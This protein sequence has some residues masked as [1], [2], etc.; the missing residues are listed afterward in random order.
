SLSRAPTPHSRSADEEAFLE[1]S[2]AIKA[3]L[4]DVNIIKKV[5]DKEKKWWVDGN[6]NGI[7]EERLPLRL[8][9]NVTYREYEKK[10][11]ISNAGRFWEFDDGAVIIYELPNRDHEV[12][13]GEFAFQF[14]S[15]FS[16]LSFQDRVSSIG[17]TRRRSARQPDASFVPNRLPIPSPHPSDAP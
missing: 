12:A 10:S 6:Y 1:C 13:H 17:A 4:G 14:M 2:E 8:M 16:N 9:E 11:E 15:T 7:D 5:S 3:N